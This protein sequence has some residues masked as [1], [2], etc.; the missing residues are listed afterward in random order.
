MSIT[1]GVHMKGKEGSRDLF[2]PRETQDA[3]L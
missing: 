2:L 3:E 1:A